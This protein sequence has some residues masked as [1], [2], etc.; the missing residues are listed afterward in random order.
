MDGKNAIKNGYKL[1]DFDTTN[2][3]YFMSAENTEGASPDDPVKCKREGAPGSHDTAG[4]PTPPPPPSFKSILL[5]PTSIGIIITVLI[6]MY[7]HFVVKKHKKT[8]IDADDA[9]LASL[10][11]GLQG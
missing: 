5:N 6:T 8:K 1:A 9:L 11:K 7:Y 2:C 4:Q 3:M 10:T